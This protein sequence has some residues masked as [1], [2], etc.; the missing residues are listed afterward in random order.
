VRLLVLG[1]TSFVGRHIVASAL[2]SEHLVTV[3]NRGLTSPNLFPTVERRRGDR[4]HSDLRALEHGEWDAVIDSSAVLP[5]MVREAARL[6]TDRVGLYAFIST[7]SV[8]SEL[9][10]DRID[11]DAPLRVQDDPTSE[12]INS[13]TYGGLK[14]LCESEVRQAFPDMHLIVRACTMAG[15]HDNTDR[16]TYW[17][18]R[19]A[20]GTPVLAPSRPDQ[21]IQLIHARDH[22]NFMVELLCSSTTGVFNAVGP[23]QPVT[24]ADMLQACADAAGTSP[25]VVWA[26]QAF[27]AERRLRLPL[28]I[29][30]SDQHDGIY[31]VANDRAL[32][33]GLVNR[34]LVD[35]AS[36]V[37]QWDRGREQK[38]LRVKRGVSPKREASL[39][40]ILD[41]SPILSEFNASTGARKQMATAVRVVRRTPVSPLG[42][43]IGGMA[44]REAV[45]HDAGPAGSMVVRPRASCLIA[46]TPRTGSWLLADLLSLTG[47]AGEPQE[48]F[49]QDFV[50]TF[51]HKL[52]LETREITVQYLS[53]IFATASA[54]TGV[55]SVKLQPYDFTRL[56][57][58]LEAMPGEARGADLVASW[59][60]DPRYIHLTRRNSARQAI[61]WYRALVSNVWWEF[62]GESKDVLRPTYPDFLQ[63]RWLE[64]LI[65]QNEAEWAQYFDE[66]GIAAHNVVYEDMVEDPQTTVRSVLE[67]LSLEVPSD[68]T[69]PPTRLKQMA[70]SDSEIWLKAYNTLR[71]SLPPIPPGW[72]WSAESCA[73]VAPVEA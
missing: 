12:V 23:D 1:G 71:E 73:F 67:F 28:D 37:L 54:K 47:L 61:S 66:H 48:F 49:R 18:R 9:D 62:S 60:P 45:C 10:T 2:A 39:L 27:L 29:L 41:G 22:A 17:V 36:E 13:T 43:E 6:L 4:S 58:A 21:P 53:G 19:L 44:D 15:P 70:D 14:A 7:T 64:N 72:Y 59:L 68:F 8:Y 3:F 34:A 63:V 11:E 65:A 32:A 26:P 33:A 46:T 24:F 30:L 51:S 5:R 42:L 25:R 40:E 16:F 69:V 50:R 56:L 55:F 38:R 57:S 52:G 20:R 35:T 31:R